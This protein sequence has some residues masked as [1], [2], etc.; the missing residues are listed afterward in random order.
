[1]SL[2]RLIVVVLIIYLVFQMI[3]RWAANK[4]IHSSQQHD[5]QKQMVRCEVC[6]LHVPENEALQR[7]GKFYCSQN[8][9]DGRLD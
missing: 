4:N 6:R 1:M 3:K 5:K 9:Y 7:E 2:I 8:H